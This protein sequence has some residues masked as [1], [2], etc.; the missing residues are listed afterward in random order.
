MKIRMKIT[1]TGT[2]NGVDWPNKGT[3]LDLPDD[4]ARH[5]VEAGMAEPVADFRD[6]ETAVV[7]KAEERAEKKPTEKKPP[8]G[9]TT[10]NAPTKGGSVPVK[11]A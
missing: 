6:A 5:Y 9:L 8:G 1:V 7:P 3:I 4:E 11:D 2:R 10:K